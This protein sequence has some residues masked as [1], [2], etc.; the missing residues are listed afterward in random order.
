MR[1][2]EVQFRLK[3]LDE[4]FQEPGV[5]TLKNQYQSGRIEINLLIG[6][7]PLNFKLVLITL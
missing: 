5:K 1:S 7:V 2:K 3:I 4:I 6:I